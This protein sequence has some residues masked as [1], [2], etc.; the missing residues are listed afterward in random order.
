MFIFWLTIPDFGRAS[1]VYNNLI[2]SM[3]LKPYRNSLLAEV[4]NEIIVAENK[5]R[6]AKS[7]VLMLYMNQ[8]SSRLVVTFRI[9]NE[10]AS[11]ADKWR[12]A[13]N[14]TQRHQ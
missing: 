3:E 5:E 1:Y 10:K 7:K 9:L 2:R 11:F 12:N 4:L 6:N 13:P 14:R 8:F